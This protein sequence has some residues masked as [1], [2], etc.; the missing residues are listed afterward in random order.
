MA[1]LGELLGQTWRHQAACNGTDVPRARFFPGD[2]VRQ[3]PAEARAVCE[4]CPVREDCVRYAAHELAAGEPITGV[5]GG[6]LFPHEFRLMMRTAI[7]AG[8]ET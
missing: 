2:K 7:R 8:D 6:L 3:A 1:T 4:G 5:W